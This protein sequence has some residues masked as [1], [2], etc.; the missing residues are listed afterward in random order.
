MAYIYSSKKHTCS[1]YF[2]FIIF[3]LVTVGRLGGAWLARFNGEDMFRPW[4]CLHR[5]MAAGRISSE[6]QVL[7]EDERITCA[8]GCIPARP[9]NPYPQD[10]KCEGT[11]FNDVATKQHW[12][13][14]NRVINTKTRLRKTSKPGL[15]HK[16]CLTNTYS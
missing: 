7:W 11:H 6:P 13:K 16:H 2:M 12:N 5:P 14:Q 10:Q 8:S 3:L 1:Y 15:C 4:P 9:C